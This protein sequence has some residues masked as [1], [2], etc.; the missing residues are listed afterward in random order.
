MPDK[1]ASNPDRV[2]NR[3]PDQQADPDARLEALELKIMDLE[4][5]LQQLNEVVVTQYQ[6][7]ERMRR[8][9]QQLQG[10]LDEALEGRPDGGPIHEVP[11]HY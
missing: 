5:V 10:K 9:H 6:D 1:N 2:S 4:L 7:I 11:P 8:S 3:K